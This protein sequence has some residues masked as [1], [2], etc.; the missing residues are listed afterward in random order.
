MIVQ[1]PAGCTGGRAHGQS[2]AGVTRDRSN[3]PTGS[4]ADGS[5]TQGSLLGI[6]HACAST[7]RHAD[8]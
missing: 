4:R 6:R 7:Q 3:N 1:I 8:D 5:A 2:K